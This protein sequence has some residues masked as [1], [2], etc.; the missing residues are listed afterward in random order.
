MINCDDENGALQLVEGS[1]RAFRG[2]RGPWSYT[3]WQH[4][5]ELLVRDHLTLVRARAGEAIILDDAII[6]Y[7]APNH[8]DTMRLAVQLVMVPEEAQPLY[9]EQV[10][11]QD[12]VVTV[13]S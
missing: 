4:V 7:S 11:E 2:P 12:G 6:H 9:F 3:A 1:H 5:E 13:D 8:A 10:S